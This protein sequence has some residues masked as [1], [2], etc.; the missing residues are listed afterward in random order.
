MSKFIWNQT[1]V[2]GKQSVSDVSHF[3]EVPGDVIAGHDS[4]LT[5]VTMYYT[6]HQGAINASA[7]I[8]IQKDNNWSFA[9]FKKKKKRYRGV[10]PPQYGPLKS[11]TLP[12]ACYLTLRDSEAENM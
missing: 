4:Q 7:K 8:R 9:I 1:L 10:F 11:L 12:C 3:A 2:Q 5:A 6:T